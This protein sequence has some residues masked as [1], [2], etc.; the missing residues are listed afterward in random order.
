MLHDQ[1]VYV[2]HRSLVVEVTQSKSGNATEESELIGKYMNNAYTGS[3]MDM[4]ASC[5]QI[6][7]I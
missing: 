3:S 4:D 1:E 7:M 5:G 2:I 6:R